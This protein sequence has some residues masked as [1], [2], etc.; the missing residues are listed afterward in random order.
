[1]IGN[2]FQIVVLTNERPDVATVATSGVESDYEADATADPSSY[3]AYASRMR[4]RMRSWACTSV[5]GRSSAKLRRSP[6]TAYDRAGN[7]TFRPLPPRR[8]QMLKPISFRPASGDWP[9]KCNS[10]SASLPAGLPLSFG[11]ILTVMVSELWLVCIVLLLV[12]N[13]IWFLH[14]R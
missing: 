11:V 2:S 7:V 8:S 5:I 12:G 1:M 14:V 3:S 9:P 10:A 13:R 4:S 6:L